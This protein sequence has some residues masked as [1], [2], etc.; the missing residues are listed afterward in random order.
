MLATI[1]AVVLIAVGAL[2]VVAY[3]LTSPER[4]K[5]ST[6]TGESSTASG[7]SA[8]TPRQPDAVGRPERVGPAPEPRAANVD[9]ARRA[10]PVADSVR[11]DTT[12]PA[13]PSRPR[14]A[15]PPEVV[16]GWLPQGAK[17]WTPGDT[18]RTAKPDSSPRPAIRP[19]SVP[20]A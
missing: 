2:G 14:R 6:A 15:R 11:S 13:N 17:A 4:T 16:P 1:P 20:P 3:A 8:A 12:R 18:N 7:G 9:S 19:D 5:T 10:T